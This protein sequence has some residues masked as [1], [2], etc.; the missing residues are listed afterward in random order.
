MLSL[1]WFA[2]TEVVVHFAPWYRNQMRL[3]FAREIQ[4]VLEGGRGL[5][6]PADFVD[7]EQAYARY[8]NRGFGNSYDF[9]QMP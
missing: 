6:I 9:S 3:E 2:D 1:F 5:D 4:P 7:Q 8:L